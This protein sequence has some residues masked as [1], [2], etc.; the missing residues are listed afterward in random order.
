MAVN[1]WS[2]NA[3]INLNLFL[4]SLTA[5]LSSKIKGGAKRRLLSLVFSYTQSAIKLI[6]SFLD[7]L[8]Q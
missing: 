7:K 1:G 3:I 4:R 2:R 5:I 8:W 6:R